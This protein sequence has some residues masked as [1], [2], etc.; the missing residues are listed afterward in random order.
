MAKK[1]TVQRTATNGQ[2]LTRNV[3][4]KISAVEGMVL[5]ERMRK[6]F[7]DA[8]RTGATGDARREQIRAIF[9]KSK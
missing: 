4:E 8:D 6:L 2:F 3:A 7:A 9:A 5:S 1:V